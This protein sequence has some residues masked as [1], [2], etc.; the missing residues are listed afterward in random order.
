MY[1]SELIDLIEGSFQLALLYLVYDIL[2]FEIDYLMCLFDDENSVQSKAN[3][4]TI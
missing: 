1:Y 2:S 3:V 4:I